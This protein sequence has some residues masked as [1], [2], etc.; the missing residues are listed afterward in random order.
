MA[1][2]AELSID[3]YATDNETVFVLHYATPVVYLDRK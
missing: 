1:D 2:V 3:A